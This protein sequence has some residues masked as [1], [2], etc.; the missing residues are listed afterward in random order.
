MARLVSARS[1]VVTTFLVGFRQAMYLITS[2]GS[3]FAHKTTSKGRKLLYRILENTSFVCCDN[4]QEIK[5]TNEEPSTVKSEHTSSTF[6][7]LNPHPNHG[8]RTKK[9]FSLQNSLSCLWVTFFFWRLWKYL[10]LFLPKETTSLVQF[11]CT[12]REN[13]PQRDGVGINYRHE[14]W[15]VK[16]GGTFL[17]S[18]SDFCS[19]P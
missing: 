8:N 13:F 17:S 6:Q 7:P 16:G 12:T 10:K 15:V 3:S 9:K 5:D 1:R 14:W 18:N 2:T 19:R 11:S 4:I